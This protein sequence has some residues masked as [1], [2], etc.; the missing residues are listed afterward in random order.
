M[1]IKNKIGN[2]KGFTLF[3]VLVSL[4]ILGVTISGISRL[5]Y[6]NDNASLYYDLQTIENDF[7]SL[8]KI[9]ETS[10]IKFNTKLKSN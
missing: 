8:D 6:T 9:T 4:V 10:S 2:I 3:E 5:F 7:I 1:T